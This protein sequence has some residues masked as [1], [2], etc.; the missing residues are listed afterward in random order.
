MQKIIRTILCVL[1]VGIMIWMFVSFVQTSRSRTAEIVER[2]VQEVEQLAEEYQKDIEIALANG[3]DA[4]LDGEAVDISKTD[5]DQYS[6]SVS[7]E[8]REIYMTHK[9]S[10]HSHTR[11][12][13]VPVL[14]PIR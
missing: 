4:Y 13:T 2:Y 12:N 11:T 7:H 3:Y 14:I 6:V 10:T 8:K 1:V 5:T 9:Q